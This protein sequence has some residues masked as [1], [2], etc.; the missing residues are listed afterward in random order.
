M[1]ISPATETIASPNPVA[2]EPVSTDQKGAF[3]RMW[4]WIT[5]PAQMVG[6]LSQKTVLPGLEYTGM[7]ALF[8]G[9]TLYQKVWHSKEM[10]EA[11]GESL[12]S[13]LSFKAETKKELEQSRLVLEAKTGGTSCQ[14]CCRKIAVVA[15]HRA[16]DA[17]INAPAYEPSLQKKSAKHFVT[18]DEATKK[19]ELN[20]A[21]KTLKHV[22]ESREEEILDLIEANVVRGFNSAIEHVRKCQRENP[23]FVVDLLKELL[24]EVFLKIKEFEKKGEKDSPEKEAEHLD[25]FAKALSKKLLSI[26]FPNRGKDLFNPLS[27]HV[28]SDNLF[29]EIESKVLPRRL[30]LSLRQVTTEEKKHIAVLGALK[31]MRQILNGTKEMHISAPSGEKKPAITYPKQQEFD[32]SLADTLSAM[33]Q[34]IDPTLC[35]SLTRF[36]KFPKLAKLI[37]PSIVKAVANIDVTKTLINVIEKAKEGIQPPQKPKTAAEIHARRIAAVKK[38]D[39]VQKEIDNEIELMG[40]DISGLPRI[41]ENYLK[42]K[43]EKKTTVKPG[44]FRSVKRF[45]KFHLTM[46]AISVEVTVF[47]IGLSIL[48]VRR[49]LQTTTKG[50]TK[51]IKSVSMLQAAKP[52]THLIMRKIVS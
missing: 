4:G 24:D 45:L 31:Q 7:F 30:M 35:K 29:N 9:S 38:D 33:V 26:A 13:L 41:M 40:R 39:E 25:L 11:V 47:K 14:E 49:Q 10:P 2:P 5:K 51:R 42:A 32:T 17:T 21:G 15:L 18:V 37:G 12:K 16:K 8:I 19:S 23:F 48:G 6:A 50:L 43:A 27:R 28:S 52:I 36:I 34:F 1:A 3:G 20:F 44:F 46:F 22:L